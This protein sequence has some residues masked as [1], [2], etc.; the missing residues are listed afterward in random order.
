MQAGFAHANH[1]AEEIR[2]EIQAS[3]NELINVITNMGNMDNEYATANSAAMNATLEN[4]LAAQMSGMFK[5]VQDQL[6]KMEKRV[7]DATN[8]GNNNGNEGKKKV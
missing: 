2:T 5:K 7:K 8:S 3:N 6:D 1:I 4:N